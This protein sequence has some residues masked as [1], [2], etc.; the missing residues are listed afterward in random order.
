MNNPQF[1]ELTKQLQESS[2]PELT[3][4]NEGLGDLFRSL[5]DTVTQPFADITV[6][7]FMNGILKRRTPTALD[8]RLL[9]NVRAAKYETIAKLKANQPEYFNE[10]FLLYV[11]TIKANL[12]EIASMEAKI[13]RP[14]SNYLQARIDSADSG[15]LVSYP[16]VEAFNLTEGTNKFRKLFKKKK[17]A[18]EY[19]T[20]LL[21]TSPS[22]RDQRGSRMPSSA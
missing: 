8:R 6:A 4:G 18:A 17:K 16:K 5:T 22:P 9:K 14:C 15:S 1:A 7:G 2:N 21:Y 13:M 12:T 10:H 3:F 19:E 11:D 20:C